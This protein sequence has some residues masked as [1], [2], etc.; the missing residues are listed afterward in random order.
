MAQPRVVEIAAFL[1]DD[2]AAGAFW[3]LLVSALGANV[4]EVYPGYPLPIRADR[5]IS[6]T[7]A[8]T[9]VTKFACLLAPDGSF[10]SDLPGGGG[11]GGGGSIPVATMIGWNAADQWVD[12]TYPDGWAL[13]GTAYAVFVT[14]AG[15]AYTL[16]EASDLGSY[17]RVTGLSDTLNGLVGRLYVQ[18]STGLV[19]QSDGTT[20]A[21]VYPPPES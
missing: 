19:L 16:G 15:T 4:T 8:T 13:V 7:G 17:L 6:P 9:R 2:T 11:P 21:E 18:A 5:E 12:I 14:E 1:P 10:L 3:M 20:T